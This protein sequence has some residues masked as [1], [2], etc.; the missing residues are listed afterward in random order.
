M[1][2][3]PTRLQPAAYSNWRRK[4]EM[5]I[6][7]IKPDIYFPTFGQHK[8]VH[9]LV[10]GDVVE[11]NLLDA[12][13]FDS[14]GTRLV[15]FSNPLVGPFYVDDLE[16]GD[17]LSVVLEKV[18]PDRAHGWSYATPTPGTIEPVHIASMPVRKSIPWTL[19]LNHGIARL[20]E[21]PES[22]KDL[23]I[24]LKPMIG[25]LGVA[26]DLS[27]AIT[28]YASGSFGGNMDCPLITANCRMQ[29][30]VFVRGGLLHIGDMHAA[31]SHG[32][33]SGA[34]IEISGIVRFSVKVQKAINISW[35]RGENE[36]SIFTIGSGRPLDIALQHATSEMIRWLAAD[37][38]LTEE[39]ASIV[40]S[41]CVQYLVSNAVNEKCTIACIIPRTIL[42]GVK[43]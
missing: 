9:H 38:H 11:V 29:F 33:I 2:L 37:Y 41:Q 8:P 43:K 4:S 35:P 42:K 36:N 6:H 15:E 25:C 19:D 31:Q 3:L 24:V 22:L 23:E 30:P 1:V 7:F 5:A 27:Q 17:S 12:H 34:A 13:G 10:S 14:Q 40:M 18:E 32:E 39:N 28:S 20:A 26:P 21:P 16:P